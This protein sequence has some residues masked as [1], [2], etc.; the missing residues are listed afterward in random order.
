MSL[1]AGARRETRC[2]YRFVSRSGSVLRNGNLV[3]FYLGTP[4]PSFTLRILNRAPVPV[5]RLNAGLPPKFEEII[6]KALEK[7]RKLRYQN[8]SDM[9]ADLQ[10]LHRD[11]ELAE[12]AS[13]G[14]V[15]RRSRRRA[16]SA[17]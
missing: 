3:G 15:R 12:T 6:S 5:S 17:Q 2:S 13:F 8:A 1:S 4:L 9:G 10:R 14:Y 11:I 16:D 7:D